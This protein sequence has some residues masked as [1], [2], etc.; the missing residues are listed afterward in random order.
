[1][2][3]RP[4]TPA[5]WVK[6]ILLWTPLVLFVIWTLTPLLWSL[7]ASFK[8]VLELYRAPPTLIPRDPTLQNFMV[9]FSASNFPYY[10]G[11][12][13]FLAVG[14]TLITL[15]VSTLGAYSFA[16]YAY[17]F[18][19]ILLLFVLVP[20][21][22]P[23]AALVVPLYQLFSRMGILNTYTVLL[24]SYTATA[25][26]MSTWI[27][28]GFFK[29]IPYSLEENA[30]L[31]GAGLFLILRKIMI[32]MALPGVIAVIVVAG[33]QSWNEFPF[34]LSFT[35]S[36]QMRTLPYQLY[37]LRDALGVQDW[38]VINAFS[39]VTIIP[40]VVV[41]FIF[42]KRVISGLVSGAIKGE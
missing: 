12:S 8:P 6:Q 38:S 39:M 33:V 31:D 35:N 2:I 25:V 30:R 34:V 5:E 24:I 41:F 11:N 22:I 4:K 19:H 26:P 40:V 32:P 7:S 1:M 20:R 23:R 16:R 29:G 28:A 36:A 18:R 10:F 9:V 14:S 15:V 21:I 17:P 13:V 37:L 3:L 27:L 42:Q